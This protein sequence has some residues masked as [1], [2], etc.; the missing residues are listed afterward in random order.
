MGT[1][2]ACGIGTRYWANI[3]LLIDDCCMC[4]Q[5]LKA[6]GAVVYNSYGACLFTT[7]VAMLCINEYIKEK[8]RIVLSAKVKAK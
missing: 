1:L 7:Q 5:Q 3:W 4:K 6:I 2:D 8:R